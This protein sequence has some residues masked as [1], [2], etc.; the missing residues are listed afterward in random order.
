MKFQHCVS[1]GQLFVPFALRSKISLDP[2]EHFGDSLL[3]GCPL[4]NDRMCGRKHLQ[5]VKH[6]KLVGIIILGVVQPTHTR[7]AQPSLLTLRQYF[8]RLLHKLQ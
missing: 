4:T 6:H 3:L 8:L 7:A 1:I 2:T 5:I